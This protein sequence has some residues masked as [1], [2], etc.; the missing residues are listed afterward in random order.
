MCLAASRAIA[1]AVP[2]G[3]LAH[4]S[5]LPSPLSETLYPQVAEAAARA[6]VTEG[7]ARIDPGIGAVA[8]KTAQL[9]R[10]V[11]ERQRSL[12]SAR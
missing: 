10:L 4:N 8:T 2:E 6:A 5:I 11:Q 12:P 9:R 1:A 3:D 7:L